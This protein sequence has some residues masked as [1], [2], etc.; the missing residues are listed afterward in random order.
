MGV[1]AKRVEPA[2]CP[3]A[4]QALD[5]EAIPDV[6][7]QRN[8]AP[9]DRDRPTPVVL[10]DQV[11]LGNARTRA[12]NDEGELSAT[13]RCGGARGVVASPDGLRRNADARAVC[14]HAQR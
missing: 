9:L 1:H 2:G 8:I 13:V 6:T 12:A 4:A 10:Y 14:G 11:E 5:Q 7:G 3:G